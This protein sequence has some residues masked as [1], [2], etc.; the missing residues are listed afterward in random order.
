MA[1]SPIELVPTGDH[2]DAGAVALDVSAYSTLRLTLDVTEAQANSNNPPQLCV[3]LETSADG[4]NDWREL[5]ALEASG[6]GAQRKV[7]SGL[8][9]FLRVRWTARSKYEGV[10]HGFVWSLAGDAV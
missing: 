10:A 2:A 8:D 5:A 4:A 7:L 3:W 1:A 9:S 6:I